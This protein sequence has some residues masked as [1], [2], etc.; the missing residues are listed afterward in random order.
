[1]DSRRWTLDLADFSLISAT[2]NL[3]NIIYIVKKVTEILNK[4]IIFQIFTMKSI[5][6]K[7]N[8]KESLSNQINS[9]NKPS[10]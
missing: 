1:M 3:S 4:R 7:L 10:I 8:F 6:N 2:L 5:Q 9:Y